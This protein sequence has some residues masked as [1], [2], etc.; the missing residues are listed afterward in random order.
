M[1]RIIIING[2]P[3]VCP[4]TYEVLNF[5]DTSFERKAKV[6]PKNEQKEEVKSQNIYTFGSIYDGHLVSVKYIKIPTGIPL[7]IFFDN[8]QKI[9][10]YPNI[11][12]VDM[13]PNINQV[14][15]LYFGV[16][17]KV[18]G[19]PKEILEY[20]NKTMKEE[21]GEPDNLDKETDE[22]IIAT[23]KV[24]KFDTPNKND[25]IY[26]SPSIHSE[27]F[28]TEVEK[29]K[30]D[31]D[32]KIEEYINRKYIFPIKNI[33]ANMAKWIYLLDPIN[34]STKYPVHKIY[35]P[36]ILHLLYM[37]LIKDGHKLEIPADEDFYYFEYT[38]DELR[39]YL[40]FLVYD[41]PETKEYFSKLNLSYIEM[42]RGI[43]VSD[44]NRNAINLSSRFSGPKWE[45]DFI[46]L[47]A[48][49]NNVVLECV[50]DTVAAE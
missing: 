10:I 46:D 23:S 26:H 6:I 30:T 35:I 31:V 33:I 22:N 32:K 17:Y 50:K 43:S 24:Q 38:K 27:L 8:E 41:E 1:N 3:Y 9:T 20:I 48:L 12:G 42:Q 16:W 7:E 47:D 36:E 15:A 28:K 29:F 19:T 18:S 14:W 34:P 39:K 45:D 37:N 5:I 13:D 40:Y 44:P 49:I 21:K 11:I 25:R 2:I 4:K